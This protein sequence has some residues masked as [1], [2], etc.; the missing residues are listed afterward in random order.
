[1][2]RTR[3]LKAT[4]TDK[5]RRNNEHNRKMRKTLRMLAGPSEVV[6]FNFLR[7]E[8]TVSGVKVTESR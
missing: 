3:S 1:M 2:G 4:N 6:G 5:I 8:Q 7:V